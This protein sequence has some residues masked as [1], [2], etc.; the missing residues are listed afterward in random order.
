MKEIFLKFSSQLFLISIFLFFKKGQITPI[1]ME[2]LEIEREMKNHTSSSHL[3]HNQPSHNQPPS[4]PPIDYI[5]YD[6]LTNLHKFDNEENEGDN[7]SS[8]GF[9]I[10][11]ERLID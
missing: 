3:S 11:I 1:L 8:E 6:F 2:E 4:L 5:T 7:N 9:E 10:E